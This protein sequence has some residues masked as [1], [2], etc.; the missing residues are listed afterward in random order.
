MVAQFTKN[1]TKQTNQMNRKQ[2]WKKQ[3]IQNWKNSIWKK[4]SK[5]NIYKYVSY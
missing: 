1:Q 2:I 4:K 5:R 3:I